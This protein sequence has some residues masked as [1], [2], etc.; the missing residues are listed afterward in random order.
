MMRGRWAIVATV[1]AEASISQGAGT[2]KLTA[3]K[4]LVLLSDFYLS[5]LTGLVHALNAII[6]LGDGDAARGKGSSS[7]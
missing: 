7:G 2:D 5:N 3:P 1:S 6:R 4:K